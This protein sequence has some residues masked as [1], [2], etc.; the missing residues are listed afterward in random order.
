MLEFPY[1]GNMTLLPMA[2]VWC[3]AFLQVILFQPYPYV[4]AQFLYSFPRLATRA[5]RIECTVLHAPSLMQS[6]VL[7]LM[8][9]TSCLLFPNFV[10]LQL[11]APMAYLILIPLM[12]GLI[13]YLTLR[14]LV[15]SYLA[16]Y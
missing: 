1:P 15:F 14:L 4:H 12:R 9:V 3:S 2:L 5:C 11:P 10:K 16:I 6:L 7:T 13:S 8:G